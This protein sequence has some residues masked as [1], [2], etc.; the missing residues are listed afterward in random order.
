MGVKGFSAKSLMTGFNWNISLAAE[1]V[2]EQYSG[3]NI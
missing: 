3:L 1:K 2:L